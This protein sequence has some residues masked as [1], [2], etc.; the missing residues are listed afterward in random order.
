MTDSYSNFV[1]V[2]LPGFE[3]PDLSCAVKTDEL[4][5][6]EVM[7]TLL[8]MAEGKPIPAETQAYI[9]QLGLLAHADIDRKAEANRVLNAEYQVLKSAKT[10]SDLR[11]NIDHL[12]GAYTRWATGDII[13][14]AALD[15]L[16]DPTGKKLFEINFVDINYLK[17]IN[18]KFG[19]VFGDML[20]KRV[21]NSMNAW[22]E[23]I[24]E[25]LSVVRFGGDELTAQGAVEAKRIFDTGSLQDWV[26]R[27]LKDF[28]DYLPLDSRRQR[29]AYKKYGSIISV[30]VGTVYLNKREV[31]DEVNTVEA[32]CFNIE[33]ELIE[34]TVDFPTDVLSSL[35]PELLNAD[36]LA[37]ISPKHIKARIDSLP[38]KERV[39][40]A[41]NM[42]L[43]RAIARVH[44][45]ADKK[46][47]ESK[48]A[49]K[50]RHRRG[51]NPITNS[52][53]LQRIF[54]R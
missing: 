17:E 4:S 7:Q 19:H 8:E 35:F 18:D 20:I 2:P 33:A 28:A 50:K 26:N 47:Y 6:V 34:P 36:M 32:D 3:Q 21:T 37:E 15:V 10:E 16:A 1:E 38:V 53:V 25:G 12:T 54:G 22:I 11:A 51:N 29:K 30:S 23:A 27:E 44:G 9:G 48:S 40:L 24:G 42:A 52:N 39:K 49:M 13:S 46:M 31:Q 45:P 43:E 5:D 41:D 14:Q